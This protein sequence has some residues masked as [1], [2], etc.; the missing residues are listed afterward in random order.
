M[1]LLKKSQIKKAEQI[2]NSLTEE[3]L[4]KY[5]ISKSFYDIEFFSDFF[6]SDIK[7]FWWKKIKTPSF[8]K[9]IWKSLNWADNSNIIIARW[10]WKTTSCMIWILHSLIYKTHQN[11]LYIASTGLWEEMISKIRDNLSNNKLIKQIYWD[12]N[13]KNIKLW[14]NKDKKWRQKELELSNSAR[15]ETISKGQSIRGKRP[16]KIIVD[17]PQE[18]VDVETKSQVD[19]FN[20][21]FFTSL[22]N[23]MLP[24]W[25]ITVLWTIIWNLCLVKFLK[26]E[27]K[28][29]TIEY[30][31]IKENSR[32]LWKELWPKQELDKRKR[33]LWIANFNQE[34]M[35]IP[36][37]KNDSIIKD[38]WIKT[39]N[40]IN[41]EKYDYC[42]MAV[43]PAV[44]QKEKSD[45]TWICIIWIKEE[46]RY[47]IFSRWVKLSPIQLE[48]YIVELDK[49][50]TPRFIIQEQN[51]ELKLLQDL[52]RK[53]L[54][55]IWIRATKDKFTRLLEVAGKIEFWDVLFSSKWQE[56][57]IHQLTNFPDVEHDDE[58]DAFIYAL[59]Y[60]QKDSSYWVSII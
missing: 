24:W 55:I 23:T 30:K 25:T 28:W 18:N 20:I 41:W 32:P 11:I 59:K 8:H 19:K 38:E 44:T 54:P 33:E 1:D 5:I 51:I 50:F 36:L 57:L 2:I 10:H 29:K 9:D 17:D 56:E 48:E 12:L 58:L 47:V 15:V 49:R 13:P 40:D 26:E 43:D 22:Y 7:R 46:K 34:F 4:K 45:F 52:K 6:L 3:E 16:D 14:E 35:N 31:A 53:W 42:V 27:K 21:W 37:S 39:Y 60:S